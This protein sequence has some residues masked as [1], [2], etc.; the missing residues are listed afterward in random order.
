MS[1][2]K[3]SKPVN[4]V[5]RN[6]PLV[7]FGTSVVAAE[8]VYV[9]DP[10]VLQYKAAVLNNGGTIEDSDLLKIQAFVQNLKNK[11]LWDRL[12]EL[13]VYCG[14]NLNAATTKL[15]HHAT[16]PRYLTSVNFSNADYVRGVGLTGNGTN[17]YLKTGL[18][19]AQLTKNDSSMGVYN[20]N[21]SPRVGALGVFNTG[22]SETHS[23]FYPYSDGIL[24]AYAYNTTDGTGRMTATLPTNAR[25]GLVSL[26]RT[27]STFAASYLRGMSVTSITGSVGGNIPS[28]EFYVMGRNDS[29]SPN[30]YSDYTESMY[31]IGY[32]LTAAQ[33]ST[34]NQIVEDF[35]T[36]MAPTFSFDP[37]NINGIRAWWDAN[38]FPTLADNTTISTWRDLAGRGFDLTTATGTPKY[39]TA[40]ING[41]PVIRFDGSTRLT[42]ANVLNTKTS[43]TAFAVLAPRSTVW[44]IPIEQ[45]LSDFSYESTGSLT[46][47]FYAGGTGGAM[48]PSDAVQNVFQYTTMLANGTQLRQW[49][50]GVA[51]TAVNFTGNTGTSIL[52]IGSRSNNSFFSTFD[53]AELIIYDRALTTT[54]REQ[55]EAYL[56]EKYG[57]TTR[58]TFPSDL[59]L[60]A[61]WAPEDMS[62]AGSTFTWLDSSGN[63]YTATRTGTI[64]SITTGLNGKNAV[65]GT[66]GSDRRLTVTTSVMDNLPEYSWSAILKTPA[67]PQSLMSAFGSSQFSGGQTNMFNLELNG[68][69]YPCAFQ[70]RM[71]TTQKTSDGVTTVTGTSNLAANTWYHVYC[72]YSGNAVRFW[73]NG[74]LQTTVSITG[75]LLPA[76]AF[77]LLGTNYG[78]DFFWGG[79]I[80]EIILFYEKL[81][82]TQRAELFQYMRTQYGITT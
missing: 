23:L 55:V 69:S 62:I 61:R 78:A 41:K 47:R 30:Y 80:S 75:A 53:L 60:R 19:A 3:S 32:G 45:G 38:Q 67:T 73:V 36:S 28:L 27:S 52:C 77:Y 22:N 11:G 72:D 37:R 44:N 40:I 79:Q 25:Y 9:S 66:N 76:S 49:K 43:F 24:Y 1:G 70:H 39:R 21:S 16:A 8:T 81:T 13:G 59:P 26:S 14:N 2:I 63:N 50:N 51:G 35:I 65:Q 48:G 12:I 10:D 31:F 4:L 6:F 68:G 46:G 74:T 20:Y 7:K 17:K 58:S 56:A 15:K 5:D 34:F 42:C 29:N 57:F 33:M 82:D 54:E 64:A 18:N 71:N